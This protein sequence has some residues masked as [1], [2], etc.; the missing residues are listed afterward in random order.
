MHENVFTITVKDLEK[1]PVTLDVDTPPE[2][3]DLVDNEYHFDQVTGSVIFTQARPRI[4]ARGTIAT[5]ATTRCV[6]CLE[7]TQIPVQAP[8]DVMYEDKQQIRDTRGESVA[9]EEQVVTPYNGEW[10]QPEPELRE[11][12]LLELPALPLCS[13]D[14]K[15]LCVRCGANLNEGP[16][17]CTRDDED[18][19]PWKAAL[20]GLKID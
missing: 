8:I 9:P 2:A 7:D 1:G 17:G 15:G 10:I 11:A 5:V 4:L 20:K 19:S 6:R 13:E 16:C 18:V 3:L 14:C 12:I